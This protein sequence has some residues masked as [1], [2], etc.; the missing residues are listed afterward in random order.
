MFVNCYEI[1]GVQRS[2]SAGLILMCNLGTPTPYGRGLIHSSKHTT[3]KSFSKCTGYD[4]EHF[5]F[6]K[7]TVAFNQSSCGERE[8]HASKVE[9]RF[10]PLKDPRLST[11]VPAKRGKRF[12][13][14]KTFRKI[15]VYT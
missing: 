4:C 7:D 10:P 5:P 13:A 3:N 12:H 8:G 11:K 9:E 15:E 14:R 1:K 6:L 2:I